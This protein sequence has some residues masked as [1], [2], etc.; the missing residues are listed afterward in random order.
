MSAGVQFILLCTDRVLSTATVTAQSY[1]IPYI[2]RPKL[3]DAGGFFVV[4]KPVPGNLVYEFFV[5]E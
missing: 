5:R 1:S 2:D 4:C 3:D